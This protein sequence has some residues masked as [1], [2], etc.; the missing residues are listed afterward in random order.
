[1]ISGIP[2]NSFPELFIPDEYL[3]SQIKNNF[4]T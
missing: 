3:Q 1:M 4:P 2:T